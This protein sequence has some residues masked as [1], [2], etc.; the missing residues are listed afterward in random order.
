M[1]VFNREVALERV[2][3]DEELLSEIVGIYLGEYPSVLEE[4]QTAVRAG[5]ANGLYRS[6]HSLKGS[7][8][9]LGAEAAQ[10]RAL[11]LEMS[12]RQSQLSHAPEMLAD[13][14][15]LLDEL[16]RELSA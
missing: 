3:G 15:R 13:L 4:I 8:G 10:R 7:L 9:A 6:A 16:H 1:A 12:G 14:E 11:D 5:D 2:G